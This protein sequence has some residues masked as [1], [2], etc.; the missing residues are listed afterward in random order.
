MT[1]GGGPRQQCVICVIWRQRGVIRA[2]SSVTS[3]QL[4]NAT[5]IT[6][7]SCAS[8]CLTRAAALPVG[9]ARRRWLVSAAGGVL[10]LC[11]VC[12]ARLQKMR[13][14][15]DESPSGRICLT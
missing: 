11:V 14:D 2:E 9:R 10:F 7:A 3:V 12:G 15:G 8:A 13:S 6:H 1:V 5:I 4:M